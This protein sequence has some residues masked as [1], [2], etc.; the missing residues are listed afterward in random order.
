MKNRFGALV[1]AWLV[2]L[3]SSVAAASGRTTFVVS[4]LHFGPG[5][6]ATDPTQWDRFEDFRWT[7]EFAA[8]LA[9]IDRRGG[10]AAELVLNGD[11]FELWQS[12]T[13]AC[14]VVDSLD[15][16][17]SELEASARMERVL[18]QHQQDLELLARF[19]AKQQNQITLV[20][21]NHDAA[22]MFPAVRKLVLDRLDPSGKRVAFALNGRWKSGDGRVVA[23]HGH[24]IGKDVNHFPHWPAPFIDVKGTRRLERPWGEQ[25][26]QAF[27][28]QY[29]QMFPVIDN[30]S[31]EA[32]GVRL[33]LSAAPASKAA[34]AVSNLLKFILLEESGLQFSAL[35]SNKSRPAWGDG[36]MDGQSPEEFLIAALATDDPLRA[37]VEAALKNPSSQA[38]GTPLTHEE[39]ELLCTYRADRQSAGHQ[40]STCSKDTLSDRAGTLSSVVAASTA[41]ES[42]LEEHFKAT[43]GERKHW[44]QVFIYSH[45]HKADALV[46]GEPPVQV[47]NSGAWQRVVTR[48]RLEQLMGA[49]PVAKAFDKMTVDTLDP[50]YTFVEVTSSDAGQLNARLLTW[51][52]R[53]AQWAVGKCARTSACAACQGE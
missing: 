2:L 3:L 18:S 21:G 4:D 34:G 9:E 24:Q 45:T 15:A 20:P 11:T 12:K 32:A 16:G 1:L 30:L 33:G 47:L 35:L 38:S 40:V 46:V 27:Y 31:S 42:T 28:N 49:K 52:K 26:V 25:F 23:E 17:C 22:L 39:V 48:K 14:N 37:K 10:G 44:P 53:N 50:C 13:V 51:E 36:A 43:F 6:D 8:F 7:E 19:S 5:H 41:L 29:E